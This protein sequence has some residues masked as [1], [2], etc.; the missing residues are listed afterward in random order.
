MSK[1]SATQIGVGESFGDFHRSDLQGGARPSTV[2]ARKRRGTMAHEASDVGAPRPI[3][4]RSRS[5]ANALEAVGLP[6]GSSIPRLTRSAKS[7]TAL[8]LDPRAAFVA[9]QIDGHMTV[10]NILDLGLMTRVEAL[11]AFHRLVKLGVVVFV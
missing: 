3:L 10:Q 1:K 4:G 5:T 11:A 8:P 7:L 2:L 9:A 6:P